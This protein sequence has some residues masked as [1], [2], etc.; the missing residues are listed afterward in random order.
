MTEQTDPRGVGWRFPV[1][2]EKPEGGSIALARHDQAV[3][4]S[5]LTIIGTAKGERVMRPTFGCGIHERVFGATDTTTAALVAR[6]V[7]DALVDWEPRVEVHGVDVAPDPDKEAT[8]LVVVTYRVL[9]TNNVFNLVYPF[10]LGGGA[11]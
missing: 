2:V 5:I 9:S 8:L 11:G 3:K 7:E 1:Q 10:Y 6:D 4:Q